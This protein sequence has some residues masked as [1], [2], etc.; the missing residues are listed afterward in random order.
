VLLARA[1]EGIARD[2]AGYRQTNRDKLRQ[3]IREQVIRTKR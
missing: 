1:D 3:Y 2:Y